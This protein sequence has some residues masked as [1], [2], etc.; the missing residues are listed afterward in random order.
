MNVS[1]LSD[2]RKELKAWYTYASLPDRILLS[3]LDAL[4]NTLA[5]QQSIT[6]K[7]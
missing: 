6:D 7:R 5:T 2:I 4:V 1:T 3:H